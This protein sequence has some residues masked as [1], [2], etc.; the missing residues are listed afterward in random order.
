MLINSSQ[1]KVLLFG[2][3]AGAFDT[4]TVATLPQAPTLFKAAIAESG[5]GRDAELT[6]TI[7]TLGARYAKGLGCSID[8]VSNAFPNTHS[9]GGQIISDTTRDPP[10]RFFNP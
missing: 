8:D 3:S 6:N 7:N 1:D 2:Q 5:G 10:I 4:F 9:R